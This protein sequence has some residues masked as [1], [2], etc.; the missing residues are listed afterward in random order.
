MMDEGRLVEIDDTA[1]YV[2]QRGEGP[3]IV[4][5]HGGPGLDHRE[6]GDYLDPLTD[7]YRLVLVDQR[8]QGRSRRSNPPTWT[9]ERFAA[10]VGDLAAALELDRHAVLGH[11]FG[12]FVAL[13]QAVDHPDPAR[14]TIASDGVPSTRFLQGVD[15]ALEHF[16]PVHLRAQIA[17]AWAREAGVRTA[18]EFAVLWRDQLPFH[19]AD[20]LDPRIAEYEVRSAGAA[21]A[22]DVLRHFEAND[23]GP[24]EVED[25]LGD[26]AGPMLVIAGRHERTCPLAAS[27]AIAAGVPDAELVVLEHSAHMGFVEE[28]EAY[29]GAVRTFLDGVLPAR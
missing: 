14:P 21:Y 15:E 18:A 13:Q 11:S 27:E 10:D 1:L 22:P 26:V 4:A 23:Y 20:P 17:E 6:F 5:L 2:V 29:L 3:A 24:I 16:E 12:A 25:R 9:L 28:P 19:F 7:R 8:G